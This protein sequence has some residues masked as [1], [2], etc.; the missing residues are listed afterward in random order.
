MRLDC[1]EINGEWVVIDYETDP[2][3]IMSTAKTAEDAWHL[4]AMELVKRLNNIRI[5]YLG[6]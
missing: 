4:V 3:R 6:V 5:A 1:V 2:R